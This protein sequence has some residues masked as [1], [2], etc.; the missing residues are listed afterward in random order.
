MVGVGWLT[1]NVVLGYLG[2][3]AVGT[4]PIGRE[5]GLQVP[6]PTVLL[7]GGLLAGIVVSAISQ[8][9]INATAR[10]AARRARRSLEKAVAEVAR[11]RV[12]APAEAEVERYVTARKA[13][14]RLTT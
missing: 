1:L 7:I 10:G 4:V 5:G 12:L 2:L 3:P 9:I 11:D 13:L 14:D 6:L 8:L